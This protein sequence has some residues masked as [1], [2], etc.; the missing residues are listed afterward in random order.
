MTSETCAEC[1][2][3]KEEHFEDIE[4][5]II[6]LKLSSCNKCK[7]KKFKPS[8]GM[9]QEEPQKEEWNDFYAPKSRYVPQNNSPKTNPKK[10]SGK[11][12][13]AETSSSEGKEPDEGTIVHKKPVLNSQSSGS[14]NQCNRQKT[15]HPDAW[16]LNHGSDNSLSS[17]KIVAKIS[18]NYN[19]NH[20][21]NSNYDMGYFFTKD[22]KEAVQKLNGI[23][24]WIKDEVHMQPTDRGICHLKSQITDW[25]IPQ[26]KEKI[27]KILG[28]F[29]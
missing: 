4:E 2:H 24:D 3:T 23:I 7:C 22:V 13:P 28:D 16:K 11:L 17:K 8:Q 19:D 26:A 14:D 15:E 6:G 12:Q 27:D 1:G 20:N 29:K 18:D 9:T 25:I 21:N 5:P 10:P